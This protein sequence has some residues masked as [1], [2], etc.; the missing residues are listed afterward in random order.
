MRAVSGAR[1]RRRLGYH[2]D[3]R[4]VGATGMVVLMEPGGRPSLGQVSSCQ[5]TMVGPC[6][7]CFPSRR[8]CHWPCQWRMLVVCFYHKREVTGPRGLCDSR[9]TKWGR[10]FL[11]L[12]SPKGP[13]FLLCRVPCIFVP[14]TWRAPDPPD[15][16]MSFAPEAYPRALAFMRRRQ[17]MAVRDGAFRVPKNP[18]KFPVPSRILEMHPDDDNLGRERDKTRQTA[19]AKHDTSTQHRSCRSS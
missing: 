12:S 5:C 17:M 13:F 2:H 3:H 11:I 9:S 6:A 1:V 7:V 15:P 19:A 8:T 18:G 10:P 14:C 16:G 4:R